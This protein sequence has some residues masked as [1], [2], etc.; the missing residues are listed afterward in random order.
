M[1][2]TTATKLG[3]A[4]P[5]E[6]NGE[7]VTSWI[8]ITTAHPSQAGCNTNLFAFVANSAIIAAWDPG[9]GILVDREKL[10]MPKAVTTWWNLNWLGDNPR[11][12]LS[13]AP[14][15]CPQAFY[16]ATTSVKSES[17]TLVACCPR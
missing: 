2:T 5:P 16:T 10:C 3:D 7:I 9:Y 12:T 11:T 13:L 8:P 1:S 15:V 4:P 14:I 17:S 6:T